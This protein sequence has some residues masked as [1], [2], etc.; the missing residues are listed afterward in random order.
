MRKEISVANTA[1]RSKAN[2]YVRK[3]FKSGYIES[4]SILSGGFLLQ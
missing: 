2:L 3:A 1:F 4:D